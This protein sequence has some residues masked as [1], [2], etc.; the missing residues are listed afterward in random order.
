MALNFTPINGTTNSFLDYYGNI[1]S[2]SEKRSSNPNDV[3]RALQSSNSQSIK[4]EVSQKRSWGTDRNS[5][6][7]VK[8]AGKKKA[9]QVANGGANIL[10]NNQAPSKSIPRSDKAY[11]KAADYFRNGLYAEVTRNIAGEEVTSNEWSPVPELM[12]STADSWQGVL[13]SIRLIDPK[14][15]TRSD[16][17]GRNVANKVPEFSKFFLEGVQESH[18]EKVQIV[19]T[20]N[21]FYAFFYGEKPPVYTFSGHLLNLKNYNWM[22]EFMYY[23]QNFWRGTK[24]VEQGAR[25]FLTYN[26]QQIQGYVLG[27]STNVNA[28]TDKAAPFSLQV[29]VTKRLIFT[30]TED[31]IIRDN[32]LPKSSTGFLNTDAAAFSEKLVRDQLAGIRPPSGL[33]IVDDTNANRGINTTGKNASSITQ[34]RV[35]NAS[36]LPPA[37]EGDDVIDRTRGGGRAQGLLGKIGNFFGF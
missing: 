30:G 12:V 21:D 16:N 28:V 25:V 20:F 32:L 31:G 18:S 35:P 19:E 7:R 22:N 1:T 8:T 2:V 23:Y 36:A 4:E 24:A 33:D 29:L 37:D 26:Y 17:G 11:G 27:I 5:T 14:Q 3:R 9:K 10:E 6:Q 13:A 34:Q 15:A